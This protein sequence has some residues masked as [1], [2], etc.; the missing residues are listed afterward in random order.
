MKRKSKNRKFHVSHLEHLRSLNGTPLASFRSRGIAFTIDI[1][2][3][4][5]IVLLVSLPAAI[6]DYRTGINENMIVTFDLFLS[7]KGIF[8]LILYFGSLTYL[9]NGQTL[10]KRLLKIR[11]ISL[12]S[13]KLTIWQSLERSMG[14]ATSSFEAGF[15]FIQVAWSENS[16]ATHDKLAE[17]AVI[18]VLK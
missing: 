4:L 5:I 2:I 9:W 17:T 1:F 7:L 12:K 3:I 14:Y 11:V 15:G 18:K 6:S 16:Q 10:G 13:D 8:S